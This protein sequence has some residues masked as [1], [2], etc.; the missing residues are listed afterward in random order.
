MKNLKKHKLAVFLITATLLG[1][2][3]IGIYGGE[4]RAASTTERIGGDGAS[5]PQ[6]WISSVGNFFGGIGDYFGSNKKLREEN[7]RLK[8][9]NTNLQKQINDNA[10]MQ[11]END[12]LR[13]MLDLKKTQ[14]DLTLIAASV[15][16]K[17]PSGWYST[18]TIDKGMSDGIKEDQ[19]VVN[20]NRELIGRIGRT[21]DNWAE[22]VTLLDP[23]ASIGAMVKRSGAIGILEGNTELRYSNKSRFGYLSRDTDITTGDYLETSGQG[24]IYPKGLIIGKIDE[25][26]DD[27]STMSRYAEVSICAEVSS[28]KEVFVISAFKTSDLSDSEVT[29]EESKLKSK[30]KSDKDNNKD[31]DEDDDNDSDSN[32][33]NKN[34]KSNTSSKSTTSNKNSKSSD[35]D[36]EED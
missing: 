1:V 23:Q 16:A 33:S 30:N 36:D 35:S 2:I 12:E 13:Q 24:G 32:S 4:K 9:E 5:V 34:G 25:V 15:S 27:S 31:S 7:E 20:S 26:K 3:C 18:F 29:T 10:G 17:D 14:V 8:N 22:V 21:G 11:D 6:G 28:V 19:P